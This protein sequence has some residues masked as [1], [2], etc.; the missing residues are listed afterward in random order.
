M[1]PLIQVH[2]LLPATGLPVGI[3]HP[4]VWVTKLVNANYD[5][6]LIYIVNIFLNTSLSMHLKATLTIIS[7]HIAYYQTLLNKCS[8]DMLGTLSTLSLIY[9]HHLFPLR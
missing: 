9:S 6:G 3:L 1:A 2:F 5:L 4:L 8:H 7:I